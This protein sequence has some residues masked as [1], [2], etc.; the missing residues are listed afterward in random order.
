MSAI[1]KAYERDGFVFPLEAMS[2]DEAQLCRDALERAEREAV[3]DDDLLSLVHGH[4]HLLIPEIDALVRNPRVVEPVA[5][6]LGRDLLLWG[7]S[8]FIKEPGTGSFVSWH[9]DLN[10]W[11]LDGEDEVTAWVA[12]SEA[13]VASGA[14]RF[15]AGSH[16]E[17]LDH[18]DTFAAG[19]LLTRG[20]EVAVDV[21]DEE[22]VDIVLRTGEMSLHHGLLVHASSPNRSDDRRI[23][24]ALRYIGPT[25]RQVEGSVDHAVLVLGE[26][27]HGHFEP[28]P[29]PSSLLDPAGIEAARKVRASKEKVL[30]RNVDDL[31][32]VAESRRR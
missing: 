1:R 3:D 30:F 7:A 23:G 12:L 25:M 26:D 19:N 24:L 15:L 8:F 18:R 17:R 29:R 27:R 31:E 4:A 2:G 16:R 6:I 20:Q 28:L 14:M 10:Y 32:V 11:G 21:R 13:S 22:A 5:E 9:Q